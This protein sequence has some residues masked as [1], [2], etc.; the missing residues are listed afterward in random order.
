MNN[1][2]ITYQ[3]EDGFYFQET[4]PASSIVEALVLASQHNETS[5]AGLTIEPTTVTSVVL[6]NDNELP[7]L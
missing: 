5:I 4:I 2:L 7:E 6:V 1:Y 3:G